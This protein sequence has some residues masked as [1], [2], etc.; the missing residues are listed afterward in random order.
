M[1]SYTHLLFFT[2]SEFCNRVNICL[3][4]ILM[5]RLTGK[6]SPSHLSCWIPQNLSGQVLLQKANWLIDLPVRHRSV[7]HINVLICACCAFKECLRRSQLFFFDSLSASSSRTKTFFFPLTW[8]C[9]FEHITAH[10]PDWTVY[11]A[12]HCTFSPDDESRDSAFLWDVVA[13]TWHLFWSNCFFSAA[14][15]VL[16]LLLLICP[17]PFPLAPPSATVRK[18][19]SSI[20]TPASV[21]REWTELV[22]F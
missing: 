10:F 13:E 16:W 22:F 11:L 18:L 2:T 3:L 15:K 5:I 4:S 12:A 8:I 21:C 17:W 1:F 6:M 9:I 14:L 7:S 20:C 19:C